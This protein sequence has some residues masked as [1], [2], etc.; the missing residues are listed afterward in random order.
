MMTT[1]AEVEQKLKDL[2]DKLNAYCNANGLEHLS[3]GDLLSAQ[4]CIEP[5]NENHIAFLEAFIDEWNDVEDYYT[6][7]T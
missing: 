6:I 7:R 2:C 4:Y 1:E 5:R 3:A